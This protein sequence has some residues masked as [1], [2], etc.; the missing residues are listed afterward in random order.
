MTRI[1]ASVL[2]LNSTPFLQQVL[3]LINSYN[4][5][6]SS[7]R[8]RSRPRHIINLTRDEILALQRQLAQS[9]KDFSVGEERKYQVSSSVSARPSGDRTLFRP[10]TSPTSV[11]VKI[12][13]TPMA[14]MDSSST[15]K[16]HSTESLTPAKRPLKGIVALCDNEGAPTG[17]IDGKEITGYRTSLNA[18]IGYARR[19]ETANIVVFGAGKC[20]IWHIRLALALRGDEIKRITVVNRSRDTAEAMI[21]QIQ[22][23]NR[24][25]WKS[26]ANLEYFSSSA[27]SY[28]QDLGS[29]IGSADVI[30][31]TVL[32]R[33]ILF[34]ARHATQRAGTARG[35]YISAVGSWQPDMIE[36]DPELLK[37][38]ANSRGGF[39]NSRS[40]SSTIIVNDRERVIEDTGEAIQSKLSA[41]SFLEWGEILDLE[42]RLSTQGDHTEHKLLTQWL[43][44]GFIVYKSIGVS[45][46]DLVTGNFLLSVAKS[47]GLG[48]AVPGF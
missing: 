12:M 27:E 6:V 7:P 5:R 45:I 31:C 19:K 28:E 20:A 1:K 32:S 34:P 18:L 33:N 47:R 9:L 2:C 48:V 15:S 44:E 24:K 17:V 30:F 37:Y 23:E 36:L 46:T 4:G 42:E 13:V 14:T 40:E 10:F 16:E 22:G 26:G 38:V 43:K 8:R 21:S 39:R 25:I 11:G 41:D 29:L 3:S 35:I